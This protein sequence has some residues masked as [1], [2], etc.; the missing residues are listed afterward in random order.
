M[1]KGSREA[2]E[3]AAGA[4]LRMARVN[5]TFVNGVFA[6]GADERRLCEPRQR[7]AQSP[8]LPPTPAP[9]YQAP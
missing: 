6:N 2:A 9:P 8:N 7:T 4:S 1:S 5:G 3:S